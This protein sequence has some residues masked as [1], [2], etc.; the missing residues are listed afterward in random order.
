[1]S[2][3][4]V[5]LLVNHIPIVGAILTVPILLIALVARAQR[6]L[7][8]AAAVLLT[9]GALGAGAALYSG[10]GAEKAVE[11]LAGVRRGD[12]EIHE[13]RA[14]VAAG[15]ALVAA[16]AAIGLALV[17][18]ERAAPA[19]RAF[20]AA[21]LAL[22]LANAGVMAWTGASGGV[23]RHTEIRSGADA[24]GQTPAAE[25]ARAEREEEREHD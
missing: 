20:V 12:I 7:A 5:H 6:G 10:E 13:E 23:I 19:P 14:E 21:V 2:G 16:L 25:R 3:A 1:M 4:H 8:V 17:E 11:H 22:S 18:L 15:L 9:F 24:A